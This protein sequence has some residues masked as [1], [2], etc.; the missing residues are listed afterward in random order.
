M[1]NLIRRAIKLFPYHPYLE[2]RAVK[3][4]RFQWIGIQRKARCENEKITD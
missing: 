2:R 1:T 3:H 4:L